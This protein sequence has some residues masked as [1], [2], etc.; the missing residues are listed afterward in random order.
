MPPGARRPGDNNALLGLDRDAVAY[1]ALEY[2]HAMTVRKLKQQRLVPRVVLT[3]P[4]GALG[5][6]LGHIR[7][8]WTRLWASRVLQRPDPE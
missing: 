4:R 2:E 8:R 7:S 5:K 3:A 6:R 1:L